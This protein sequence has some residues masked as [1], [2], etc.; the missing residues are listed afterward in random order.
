MRSVVG[1]RFEEMV[2]ETISVEVT[3]A[4]AMVAV[5]VTFKVLEMAPPRRVR[6]A[7]VTEPRLVTER[8]VSISVD[9]GQLLPSARQTF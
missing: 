3:T 6:V 7:V 9:A 2:P 8:R 4:L 5:S 1:R